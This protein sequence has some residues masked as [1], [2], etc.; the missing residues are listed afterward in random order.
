MR[1]H[2]CAWLALLALAWIV[3]IRGDDTDKCASAEM[4][5]SPFDG[6]TVFVPLDSVERDGFATFYGRLYAKDLQL[7]DVDCKCQGFLDGVAWGDSSPCWYAWSIQVEEGWHVFSTYLQTMGEPVKLQTTEFLVEARPP[8]IPRAM[9]H[10]N[11]LGEYLNAHGLTGDGAEVGVKH[12]HFSAQILRTWRG[13]LLYLID[14]WAEQ[15]A[16]WDQGSSNLTLTQHDERYNATKHFLEEFHERTFFLR[17][18]SLQATT[19]VVNE[20]LD[21]VYLDGNHEYS[22]VKAELDAWWPKLRPW[23]L[24]MGHDYLDGYYQG[25]FGVKAAVDEFAW[26]NGHHVQVTYH[27]EEYMFRSWYFHKQASTHPASL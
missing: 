15:P 7:T 16:Y 27:E 20:S 5:I 25:T 8:P 14:P 13:N 26:R 2:R 1:G 4:M 17:M 3:G 9:A 10:R 11:E 18:V 19:H 23:G 24:M 21:F 22:Q 12:G 6:Q